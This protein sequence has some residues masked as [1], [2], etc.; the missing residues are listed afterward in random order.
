MLLRGLY[1][2]IGPKFRTLARS[3]FEFCLKNVCSLSET[4]KIKLTIIVHR[5]S[6]NIIHVLGV[7]FIDFPWTTPT[8]FL[9]KVGL[10]VKFGC[11]KQT[12]YELSKFETISKK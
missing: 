8:M 3:I 7:L 2:L 4:M 12:Q 5:V 9:V 11:F 6:V 10:I 1:T